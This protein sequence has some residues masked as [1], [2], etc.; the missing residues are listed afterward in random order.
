MKIHPVKRWL[1]GIAT[2]L[3][4]A[5]AA[6]GRA[7]PS[8]ASAPVVHWM[9]PPMAP[10]ALARVLSVGPPDV[11]V[12]A[13]DSAQHPLRGAMPAATYGSSDNDIVSHLPPGVRL[14]FAGN[15]AVRMDRLA[16]RLT[17]VGRSV[18]V[19]EGGVT[20]WDVAMTADPTAPP[21]SADSLTW[22]K[23]RYDVALRRAFGDASSA[24][25]TPTPAAALPAAGAAAGGGGRREGC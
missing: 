13:F 2:V 6:L 1:L 3:A 16:R 12:V 23:Y 18:H 20:G 25:A 5:G 17:S 15:D 10:F 7:S 8:Q 4:V 21:A 11:L 22:A 14:V 24:P 9:P 19:L